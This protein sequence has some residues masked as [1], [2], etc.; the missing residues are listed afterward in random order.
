MNQM[1]YIRKMAEGDPELQY[2]TSL[3]MRLH[4]TEEG[5]AWAAK[6]CKAS[7]E[8][9]HLKAQV[10]YAG[11]CLFGIGME[12]DVDEAMRWAQT[13]LTGGGDTQNIIDCINRN[14]RGKLKFLKQIGGATMDAML[15]D[16]N[17]EVGKIFQSVGN[18]EY[19]KKYYALAA[20]DGNAY[21]ALMLAIIYASE[22]GDESI[23]HS[24]RYLELSF[25]L[26]Q[27]DAYFAMG[28][29]FLGGFKNIPADVERAIGYF[30]KG[31]GLGDAD[32]LA[33]VG[34]AILIY[35]RN[36]ERAAEH[37]RKSADA[38]CPAGIR[39]LLMTPLYGHPL[40]DL[41][42]LHSKYTDIYGKEEGDARLNVTM[43]NLHI[44][45]GAINEGFEKNEGRSLRG[46][47]IRFLMLHVFRSIIDERTFM[48]SHENMLAMLGIKG[49]PEE[50]GCQ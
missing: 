17:Y 35:N 26:G 10:E 46:E 13:A 30:E 41:W 29:S 6:F 33:A 39:L 8:Q 48:Q 15:A 22:G 14:D 4:N 18:I 21:A 16:D 5:N 42:E 49:K 50:G 3:N 24:D 2:I 32:S 12:Q 28:L 25:D 31:A 1:D 23:L 38:G 36:V 40:D 20:E 45:I 37:L 27:T 44:D 11:M 47:D 9:G 19:T 7:A 43:Q 34:V